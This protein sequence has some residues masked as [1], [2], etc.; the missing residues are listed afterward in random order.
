MENADFEEMHRAKDE[1]VYS[2][3]LPL[4]GGNSEMAEDLTVETFLQAYRLWHSAD[5][6]PLREEWEPWLLSGARTIAQTA[7]WMS[8]P[9]WKEASPQTVITAIQ[10][11]PP[12]YRTILELT[13]R[14]NLTYQETAQ[15]LGISAVAVKVRLHRARAK[16]RRLLE[17]Q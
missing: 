11:L 16:L 6:P 14:E 2:Y 13:H 7:R 10:R 3:L 4:V 5:V 8:I 1:V 17:E 12:E 15:R 9:L